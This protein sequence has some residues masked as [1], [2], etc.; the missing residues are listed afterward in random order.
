MCQC[1]SLHEQNINIALL[2]GCLAYLC[3]WNFAPRFFLFQRIVRSPGIYLSKELKIICPEN[4]V[5][6]FEY[7]PSLANNRGH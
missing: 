5:D 7:V 6:K 3:L 2:F 1:R 4:L